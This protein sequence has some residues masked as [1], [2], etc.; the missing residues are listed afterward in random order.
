MS[1]RGR[2]L[3]VFVVALAVAAL[4]AT[5]AL[6]MPSLGHLSWD[7]FASSLSFAGYLLGA[8]LCAIVLE[9]RRL[10]VLMTLAIIGYSIACLM[11]WVLVWYP[12]Q[13]TGAWVAQEYLAKTTI[14]LTLVVS[15]AMVI[16]L[17]RLLEP[18]GSLV[19]LTR[20]ATESVYGAFALLS[21]M[22]LWEVFDTWW[23]FPGDFEMR[24]WSGLLIL[25]VAGLLGTPAL[26]AAEIARRRETAE[27]GLPLQIQVRLT[28]PRCGLEQAIATGGG[29]CAGC[30]LSIKVEVSEPQCPACGY[31]MARLDVETCPECGADFHRKG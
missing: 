19:R 5:A 24:F 7:I 20:V 10:R 28:C 27:S 23:M 16:G 15:V 8:M 3:G 30:G 22:I 29:A 26:R 13:S 18:S 6:A 2:F 12:F 25:S 17:L 31:S 21:M 9:R 1:M 11:T 4:S 14:S